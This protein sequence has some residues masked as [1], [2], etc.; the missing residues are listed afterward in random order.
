[1][2]QQ[3]RQVQLVLG[4]CRGYAQEVRWVHCKGT[5]SMVLN[6]GYGHKC[7]ALLVGWAWST[8]NWTFQL[9]LTEAGC[10]TGNVFSSNFLDA[11]SGKPVFLK[12]CLFKWTVN[13]QFFGPRMFGNLRHANT[14]QLVKKNVTITLYSSGVHK[15]Y[16]EAT[17]AIAW[18]STFRSIQMLGLLLFGANFQDAFLPTYT[19]LCAFVGATSGTC[20]YRHRAER[21]SGKNFIDW[22]RCPFWCTARFRHAEAQ[23]FSKQNVHINQKH[24]CSYYIVVFKWNVSCD[25]LKLCI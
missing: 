25:Q 6:S 9:N 4:T 14:S 1:M 5:L 21:S 20:I 11:P 2:V 13:I 23:F 7:G 16:L 10:G 12:C 18:Q 17:G 3:V 24:K 8:F 19:V 22:W 15:N